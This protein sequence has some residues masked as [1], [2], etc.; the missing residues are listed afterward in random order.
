MIYSIL[1]IILGFVAQQSSEP[2]VGE[3][4]LNRRVSLAINKATVYNIVLELR[5]KHSIPLSFI[6]SHRSFS[7]PEEISI[8]VSNRTIKEVLEMVKSS[9]PEYRYGVIEGHLVLYANEPKYH[10]TVDIASITNMRRFEAIN[11]YIDSLRTR[12]PEFKELLR[13]PL[14]GDSRASAF[15]EL[16]SVRP[17]RTVLQG[18]AQLLGN[19]QSVVFSIVPAKTGLPIFVLDVVK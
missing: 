6:Q 15:T 17:K 7:K 2:R 3:T 18:F 12:W 13:P 1:F 8:N 10:R 16:V 9:A 4:M 19:N 5:Q 14:K 11:S